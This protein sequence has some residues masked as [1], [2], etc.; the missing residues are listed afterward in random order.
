MSAGCR[1][2]RSGLDLVAGAL[3]RGLDDAAEGEDD[4][5]DQGCDAGHQQAVLDGGRTV[6]VAAAGDVADELEHELWPSVSGF[7]VASR[8]LDSRNN[9]PRTG[10]KVQAIRTN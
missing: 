3:E 9:H 7:G 1:G 4:D 5:D 2:T 6:L 10:H 8:L